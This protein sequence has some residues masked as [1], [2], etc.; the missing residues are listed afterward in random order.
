[1]LA[2]LGDLVDDV[3]VRASGAVRPGTDTAAAIMRRQGGSAA[4]VAVAAARLGQPVRFI[5]NVGDDD[6]GRMLVARLRNEGVD[7]DH[8]RFGGTTGTIIALVDRAGERSFLTDRGACTELADPAPAWLDGVTCL[9]LPLYSFVGRPLADTASA[10]AESASERGIALSVDLS[11][12]AVIED[13]GV[14]ETRRLLARISPTVVFAN[15]DESE[16]I[17]IDGSIASAMTIV[18]RGPDPALLFGSDGT[19]H[20]VPATA[21]DEV[22]DTTGAGDAFA[23]GFLTADR[24]DPIAAVRSGHRAAV[25]HLRR[26]AV[27]NST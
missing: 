22:R 7:V 17:G 15:A 10:T 25:A 19:R 3:I 9:H 26:L 12:V 16:V 13:L 20:E 2:T 6:R 23:A 1:M 4:N 21:V 5:G 27:R 24:S 18:K 8:V 14:E 11:S